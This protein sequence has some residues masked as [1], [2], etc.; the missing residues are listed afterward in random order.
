MA[1]YSSGISKIE[2]GAIA[3]DGGPGLTLATVGD[4]YEG[5][6]EFIQEDHAV[7]EHYSEIADDPFLIVTKKGKLTVKFTVVDVLPSQLVL[8]LGGTSAGTG[9]AFTWDSPLTVPSI[10]QTLKITTR[11]NYTIVIPRAKILS[12]ISWNLGK[13]EVAKVDVEATV[14]TPTKAATAPVKLTLA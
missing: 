3:G 10:E 13:T 2:M 7:T 6:A 4:I 5:T 8:F 11:E 12:K 14:M 9:P 1:K